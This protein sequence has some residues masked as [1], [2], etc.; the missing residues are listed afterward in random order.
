MHMRDRKVCLLPSLPFAGQ[1]STG[2]LGP[3]DLHKCGPPMRFTPGRQ[4]LWDSA[5][6]WPASSDRLESNL[7]KML[8]LM[9][10]GSRLGQ[11]CC[12]RL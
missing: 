6:S 9:R 10:T 3:P 11:S 5:R 4:H 8:T 2:G 7:I 12:V 1:Q